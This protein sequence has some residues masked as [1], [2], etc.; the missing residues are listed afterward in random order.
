MA[1]PDASGLH[2]TVRSQ[3]CRAQADTLHARTGQ[4]D[5]FYACHPLGRFKNGVEQD[6]PRETRLCLQLCNILIG[7]MDVPGTFDLWQHDHVQ[8]M[9]GF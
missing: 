5:F 2:L 3:V 8:L 6:R 1:T 7:E 9:T 4:C